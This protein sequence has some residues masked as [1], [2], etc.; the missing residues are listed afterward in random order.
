MKKRSPRDDTGAMI[1]I[2]PEIG[3]PLSSRSRNL[4]FGFYVGFVVLGLAGI[5]AFVC[6]SSLV[7]GDVQT[8]S[9]V[10]SW[11]IIFVVAIGGAW[12]G[13]RFAL[14]LARASVTIEPDEVVVRNPSKTIRV[15]I[16]EVD[17]FEAGRNSLGFG[18][19][20]PGIAIKYRDGTSVFIWTLGNEC[21][22]WNIGK[23]VTKWQPVAEKMNALL[24]SLGQPA[25]R[26]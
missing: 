2:D 3:I 20:V 4:I 14:G 9:A 26:D 5:F 22:D 19:P 23:S 1:D 16:G 17:K 6:V 21:L 18:N 8:V 13:G 24:A 10:V 7:G 15:P 11:L 12:I 25:A